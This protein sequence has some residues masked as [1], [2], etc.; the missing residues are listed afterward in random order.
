M[1][2]IKP[3]PLKHNNRK[4]ETSSDQK[5]FKG[6]CRD[7]CNITSTDMLNISS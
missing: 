1:S 2:K 4:H 3:E 5:T 6:I 7:K